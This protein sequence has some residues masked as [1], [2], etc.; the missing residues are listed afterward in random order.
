MDRILYV[1]VKANLKSIR[2]R[3][4][5]QWSLESRMTSGRD[6]G[7]GVREQVKLLHTGDLLA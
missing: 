6:D 4:G 2:L 3:T 5:S 1:V 7:Q